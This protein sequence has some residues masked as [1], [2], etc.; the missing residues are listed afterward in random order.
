MNG[1]I[2]YVIKEYEDRYLFTAFKDGLEKPKIIDQIILKGT[3]RGLVTMWSYILSFL[4]E[5][6]DD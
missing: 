6:P 2:V 4:A 3:L 1:T 5:N